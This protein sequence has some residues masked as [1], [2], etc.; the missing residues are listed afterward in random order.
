MVPVPQDSPALIPANGSPQPLIPGRLGITLSVASLFRYI[1]ASTPDSDTTS[2]MNPSTVIDDVAQL[3]QQGQHEAA[4]NTLAR[5]VKQGDLVAMTHL[6]KRLLIGDRAPTLTK[7]AISFLLEAAQ[8][9]EAEAPSILS[10]L[11]AIGFGIPQS[12][13]SAQESIATAANRGWLPAQ[14]QLALLSGQQPPADADWRAIALSI[15]LADWQPIPHR[16]V[17][18]ES[19]LVTRLPDFINPAVCSW[20]IQRASSRLAKALV[21]DPVSGQDIEHPERSNTAAN[22][23]LLETD[24]IT[25]L[26][27]MR[28]AAATAVPFRHL[29]SPFVLH[30]NPGE[31][32]RNHFDFV[33]PSLP[34]YEEEIHRNG[35]RIITFLIYLN[36]GYEGGSTDFPELGISHAGSPGEGLFFS[37]A[38]SDGSADLRTLHAGRPPNS[39][40]K[41]IISQ[42]IRNRPMF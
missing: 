38:H 2:A 30:Y 14:R 8:K 6:A 25:I 7:Q 16:E 33:D 4:I 19:P 42:F 1:T 23:N 17:L 40:E 29:E 37:N 18:S 28:I 10:V 9:G 27:Q 32:I 5:A 36:K 26:V 34:N 22:F 21:Y 11:F 20:L 31:E 41:W 39:G 35:Q 15:D 12:W 13:H 24:L 3:D